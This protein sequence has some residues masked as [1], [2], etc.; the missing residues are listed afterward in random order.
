MISSGIK[1]RSIHP[2]LNSSCLRFIDALYGFLTIFILGLATL[3]PFKGFLY[4]FLLILAPDFI[5]QSFRRYKTCDLLITFMFFFFGFAACIYQTWITPILYIFIGLY[6]NCSTKSKNF[7]LAKLKFK[8]FFYFLT[9]FIIW[10][11]VIFGYYQ[12]GRFY[13]YVGDPN[14]AAAGFILILMFTY[15]YPNQSGSNNGFRFDR[16]LFYITFFILIFATQSRM[17]FFSLIIF[18]I[19]SYLAIRS[20]S[21]T[22]I[23]FVSLFLG[24]IFIQPILYV[25]LENVGR[26]NFGA[27][28]IFDRLMSLND[29]SNRERIMLYY[30]SAKYFFHTNLLDIL[31]GNKNLT[32]EIVQLYGNIPHNWFIQSLIS[33]GIILTTLL[34][35]TMFFVGMSLSDRVIPYFFV[36][37][38]IGGILSLTPVYIGL[39]LTSILQLSFPN[40]NNSK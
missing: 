13:G 38:L 5:R 3:Y 35:F 17:A 4:F 31:L 18:T 11:S 9:I 21:L 33:N 7:F 1:K 29:D 30:N 39:I 20:K 6:F 27:E 8:K 37:I 32:S 26:Y 22:R 15:L 24:S 36:V 23:L 2:P 16:T 10:G 12:D 34:S 14:F 19:S 25:L 40:D 28:N